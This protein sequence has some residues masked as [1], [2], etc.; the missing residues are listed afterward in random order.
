M[1]YKKLYFGLVSIASL[2]AFLIP[3]ALVLGDILEKILI[4]NEE[5][6]MN[7]YSYKNCSAN[8][9]RG[10][11]SITRNAEEISSCQEIKMKESIK[12]RSYRFKSNL[13]DT[14]PWI[15]VFAIVFGFHYKGFKRED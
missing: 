14:L 10:K 2:L 3:S 7:D 8:D 11:E 5:Y 15:I 6:V 1:N 12:N 4:S 13:I 9:Y